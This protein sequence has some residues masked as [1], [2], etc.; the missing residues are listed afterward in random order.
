MK[1]RHTKLGIDQSWGTAVDCD[2][3]LAKLKGYNDYQCGNLGYSQTERTCRLSETTYSELG[4]AVCN[5][6]YSYEILVE[7]SKLTCSDVW[8]TSNVSST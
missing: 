4:R 6:I 3:V 7:G 2:A 1:G 5:M 8:K